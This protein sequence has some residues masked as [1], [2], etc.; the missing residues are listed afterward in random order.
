VLV[1]GATFSKLASA[2]GCIP[3]P[4]RQVKGHRAAVSVYALA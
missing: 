1:S 2:A 4:D 3:F